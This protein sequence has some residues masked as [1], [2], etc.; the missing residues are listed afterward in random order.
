MSLIVAERPANSPYIDAITW[1]RTLGDGNTIRPAEVHWHL[2]LVR[3][4]GEQK[5][6]AVGPWTSAGSVA[7]WEGAEILWIRLSLGTYMPH[8]PTRRLCDGETPL[9]GAASRS[10]WLKGSAWQFPDADNVET[11]IERLAR[12][13]VLVRDPVVAAAIEDRLPEIAPRTVR[14][15][16]LQATGQSLTH[17]RQ[18][19]RAQRA[20]ALLAGGVSIL[21]AV[22]EAGFY[23]QPHLTR[24]L[25]R[26]IGYTP[27]Q[28]S[29]A[30]QPAG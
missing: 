24:A 17:I 26:F 13:E 21:D 8:L 11:F 10:F 19:E 2:V 7:W 30:Q 27:A 1:G 28:L 4:Q 22:F 5:L 23:D 25:K 18:Y 29:R 14:H 3:W 20:A 16:F 6:L 12:A 15:H 9:P